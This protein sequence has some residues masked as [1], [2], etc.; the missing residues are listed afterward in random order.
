MHRALTNV[1][2]TNSY[3]SLSCIFCPP[4]GFPERAALGNKERDERDKQPH[5]DKITG[6][7]EADVTK[8]DRQMTG[9]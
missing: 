1:R 8:G 4:R 9:R 6:R 7:R 5:G 3:C 2:N